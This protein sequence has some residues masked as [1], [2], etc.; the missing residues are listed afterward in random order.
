MNAT[1][2]VAGAAPMALQRPLGG[3]NDGM[4]YEEKGKTERG[5]MKN[6]LVILSS[7][8]I[9]MLY[10]TGNKNHKTTRDIKMYIEIQ[11]SKT[12]RAAERGQ[13]LLKSRWLA[14]ICPYSGHINR[15]KEGNY[16]IWTHN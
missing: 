10:A 9:H 11:I 13:K 7:M 8:H 4:W 5:N 15:D 2:V 3:G 16:I 14:N 12:V 6:N 1:D